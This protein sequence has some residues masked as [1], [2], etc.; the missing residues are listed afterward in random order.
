MIR[1]SIILFFTQLFLCFLLVNCSSKTN[2]EEVLRVEVQQLLAKD[3]RSLSEAA[4]NSFSFGVGSSIVNV[5][6]SKES[7]DSL[8]LSPLLPYIKSDLQAKNSS[9]LEEL[10][11]TPTARLEFVGACLYNN[12][13]EITESVSET[14]KGAEKL[15]ASISWHEFTLDSSKFRTKTQKM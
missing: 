9:E 1:H 15:I 3:V 14:F 6:I 12:K 8:L 7:Q 11:S 5:F 10:I 4:I 2:N 13:K